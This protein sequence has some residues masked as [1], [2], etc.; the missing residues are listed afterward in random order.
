MSIAGS[1]AGDVPFFAVLHDRER[2]NF[3][4]AQSSEVAMRRE[5]MTRI[6]VCVLLLGTV[7][8]TGC[9]LAEHGRRAAIDAF[10][11]FVLDSVVQAPLSQPAPQIHGGQA[12]LPVRVAA[13]VPPPKDRQECLSSMELPKPRMVAIDLTLARGMRGQIVR[14]IV[15]ITAPQPPA[16]L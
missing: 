5:R 3:F 2:D 13:A 14:R 10:A 16:T 11:S 1:S 8:L 12:L 9:R 7:A 4:A 15:V 6:G